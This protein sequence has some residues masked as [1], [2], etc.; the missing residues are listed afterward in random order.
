MLTVVKGGEREDG[1]HEIAVETDS[2]LYS[3][4]AAT[5]KALLTHGDSVDKVFIELHLQNCTYRTPCVELHVWHCTYIE[6]HLQNCTD[7]CIYR[8]AP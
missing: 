4:M 6:L 2:L 5:Q 3:G 7:N 8:T 1:Q